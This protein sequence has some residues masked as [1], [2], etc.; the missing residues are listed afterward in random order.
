MEL[1]HGAKIWLNQLLHCYCPGPLNVSELRTPPPCILLR[2]RPGLATDCWRKP[3]PDSF[4]AFQTHFPHDHH[5]E[6]VS[7]LICQQRN[8]RNDPVPSS[9]VSHVEILHRCFWNLLKL[10]LDIPTL[11]STRDEVYQ[12][13]GSC[14]DFSD[15]TQ[16]RRTY[17]AC[18]L[19]TDASGLKTL[20]RAPSWRM[21]PKSKVAPL[22]SIAIPRLQ[23]CGAVRFIKAS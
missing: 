5:A 19:S 1:R 7:N 3:H 22:K 6:P 23:L 18:T 13:R 8:V 16:L 12:N 17:D 10:S 11:L 15:W 21:L 2:P 4:A 14:A 20:V 9:L